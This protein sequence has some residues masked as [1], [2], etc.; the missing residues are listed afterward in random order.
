MS[1]NTIEKALI[2]WIRASTSYDAN[3]VIF[4]DQNAPKPSK[5]YI[6]IRLTSF[7]DIGKGY[8]LAI[9]AT[10]TNKHV[11]DEEFTLNIHCYGDGS[12]RPIG[13]LLDL[14]ASASDQD[15]YEILTDA[16]IAL[17]DRLLGPTDTSYMLD[18]D[19][20]EE[21]ASMDLLMRIPWETISTTTGFI[22]T[23][24]Y[25][26]TVKDEIHTVRVID[27]TI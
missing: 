19:K 21:R 22:S 15:T 18:N 8:D 9:S 13:V 27:E 17:V 24:T 2:D 12:I 4:L 6:G 3:H 1:Y 7:N 26:G 25:E 10:G 11:S 16:T 5:P 14:H 20:Y 23:V